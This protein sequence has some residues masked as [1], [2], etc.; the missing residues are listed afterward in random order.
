M[1][2]R[3]LTSGFYVNPHSFIAIGVIFPVLG[4]LAVAG[5]F[6]ARYRY[7]LDVKADDWTCIPALVSVSETQDSFHN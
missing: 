2:V 6:A 5:R 1:T 3:Y 7:R 4:I